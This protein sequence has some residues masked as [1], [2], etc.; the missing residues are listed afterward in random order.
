[1]ADPCSFSAFNRCVT[2][3]LNL[4]LHVDFDRR[5]MRGRAALTV[6]ALRDRFSALV[7]AAAP[8]SAL[9]RSGVPPRPRSVKRTWG[10][11]P[12]KVCFDPRGRDT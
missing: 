10:T 12:L 4:T 1:M 9:R 11:R 6:E 3:H 2:K 8:R 5:V 7:T